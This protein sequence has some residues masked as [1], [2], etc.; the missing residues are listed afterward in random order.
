MNWA[1]PILECEGYFVTGMFGPLPRINEA[2]GDF[3]TYFL[4]YLI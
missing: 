4:F 3:F 1:V 2:R